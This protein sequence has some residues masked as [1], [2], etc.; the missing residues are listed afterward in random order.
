MKKAW[1]DVGAN[2]GSDS[3]HIAHENPN[4][5]VYGFEPTPE[6]NS[7]IERQVVN[8]P[9]YTLV[10]KAVSDFEGR[11]VFNV[12]GQSDWGCSS[13]LEFSDNSKNEWPGRTD[14]KVTHK[15]EV[16]VIRLDK[17]I[18]DNGIEEIEYIHIDTQGSDLKVL[19]GLGE[20]L[21]I[22]KAG[23]MEAAGK[24]NILYNDQ[25]SESSSIEFL[26]SK[27]FEIIEVNSNDAHR[28]EVN[29]HFKRK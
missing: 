26:E 4:L 19:E 11:S 28:N 15:I 13:L 10:K 20:K 17:F 22:V 1:F 21:S 23:V 14:F 29:I 18:E 2:N 8:L 5:E 6:L 9:N 7:Y 3:I 24:D 25:N 12:A 16:D 27:G